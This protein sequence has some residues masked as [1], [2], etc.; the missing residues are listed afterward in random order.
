[1]DPQ[2]PDVLK[3]LL[4]NPAEGEDP[5]AHLSWAI[6]V[7]PE[8]FVQEAYRGEF[9]EDPEGA[10]KDQHFIAPQE[11]VVAVAAGGAA[12]RNPTREMRTIRSS[13]F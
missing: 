13:F 7:L 4:M 5:L 3:E 9:Q 6:E 1:V 11:I 8:K 10:A 12:E 2:D